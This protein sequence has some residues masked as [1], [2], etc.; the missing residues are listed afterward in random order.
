MSRKTVLLVD[1]DD[2]DRNATAGIVSALGYAVSAHATV[3]SA[4][5]ELRKLMRQ[6]AE[7]SEYFHSPT[8]RNVGRA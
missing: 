1:P 3:E 4:A 7:E 2:R 8:D 6:F 5:E